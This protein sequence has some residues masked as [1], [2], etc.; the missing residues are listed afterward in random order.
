MDTQTLY[1]LETI[2]NTVDF[3]VKASHAYK[4]VMEYIKK[5]KMKNIDGKIY[6]VQGLQMVDVQQAVGDEDLIYTEEEMTQL[7]EE[8]QDKT[9]NSDDWCTI[10]NNFND[11]L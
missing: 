6:L 1:G 7:Q 8:L 2:M 9:Y 5:E 3:D 10:I 4:N 11:N